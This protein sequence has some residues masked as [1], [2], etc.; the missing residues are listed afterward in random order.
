MRID[1]IDPP[2]AQ[3]GAEAAILAS[4]A[5]HGLT[6][7][8]PVL[9]QSSRQQAY[10]AALRQLAA[11]LFYCRCSRRMLADSPIYPGYCRSYQTPREDA[12]IRFMVKQ[13][14]VT[15]SDR[16]M[17]PQQ[18]DLASEVGDFIV[19]RRDGLVAYNLATAVDDGAFSQVIRGQDLAAVTAPQITLMQQLSLNTPDYVHLPVLCYADGV[20]L[21]KQTH[22]PALDDSRAAHNISQ[23]LTLLNHPPPDQLTVQQLLQWGASNWQLARVPAKLPAYVPAA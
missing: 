15:Y 20:K 23:A 12:A 18:V 16:Y 22:A 7:D 8:A 6:P 9:Y 14:K 3:P 4:L 21:S 10:E 13:R 11:D 1:D 5:A 17:G 2:R 19:V